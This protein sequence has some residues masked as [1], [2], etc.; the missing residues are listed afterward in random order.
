MKKAIIPKVVFSL[1][2]C[3]S[4]VASGL[5][6][7]AWVPPTPGTGL[8]PLLLLLLLLLSSHCQ[9][10]RTL[11]GAGSVSG[12][13]WKEWKVPSASGRHPLPQSCFLKAL[14]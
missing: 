10:V 3:L 6:L 12:Q 13:A 5:C 2:A 11:P 9:G 1:K 7:C 14:H 4:D 8:R